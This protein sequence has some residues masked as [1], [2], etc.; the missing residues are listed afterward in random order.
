MKLRLP[1][2][3][4][5]A[6]LACMTC[7]TT[8]YADTYLAE[9]V[10]YDDLASS[11]RFYDGGKGRD[12][13]YFSTTATNIY[14]ANGKDLNIFGDLASGIQGTSSYN[15]DFSGLTSDNNQCWAYT[16]SNMLQYWQT[17]YGVFA[18]KARTEN[19]KDPVHGY[20]YDE[21][22]LKSL[23]GTQS[24]KLNKLFYDNFANKGSGNGPIKAFGWY[25]VK[26][27]DWPEQIVSDSSPGYFDQ[28][29]EKWQDTGTYTTTASLREGT[30][31]QLSNS[32]K[33]HF[34]YTQNADGTWELTTKGQIVH[35]ELSGAGNHAITSYGFET[36]ANGDITAFYVVNS[37]DAT[38]NLEKVY[39]KYSTNSYGDA[40]ISLYYDEN[41]TQSWKGWIVTG[42]TP[43]RCSRTCSPS[44]RR[45]R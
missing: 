44:T 3:L 17:Y 7:A 5:T 16:A 14:N 1:S 34:G 28:Y 25:L 15:L 39:A 22:Y 30:M 21:S 43:L 12:W 19:R 13:A 38:Y 20:N 35:L 4:C 45:A 37:D 33:G 6:L 24:L 26:E 10:S 27:D 18:N 11:T 29:Y 2:L 32:L 8:V 31:S 23:G 41:C 40:Q 42:W 36:D 9:G